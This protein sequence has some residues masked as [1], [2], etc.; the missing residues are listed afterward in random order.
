MTGDEPTAPQTSCSDLFLY[1]LAVLPNPK[2]SSRHHLPSP[3]RIFSLSSFWHPYQVHVQ[4]L[5][6]KGLHHCPQW[7]ILTSSRPRVPRR[8]PTSSPCC[9]VALPLLWPP[10]SDP[11]PC[12][13]L[14]IHNL[15][16]IST[17]YTAALER[18]AHAPWVLKPIRWGQKISVATFCSISFIFIPISVLYFE[19]TFAELSLH[20]APLYLLY[21]LITAALGVVF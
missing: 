19:L 21:I 18:V 6:D 9:A 7:A 5:W 16:T 13:P 14:H 20:W 8:K 2:A 10:S 15:Q 12:H 17:F 11:S 4:R 3:P 1:L